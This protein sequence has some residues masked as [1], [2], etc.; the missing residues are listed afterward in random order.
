MVMG[1]VSWKGGS[2]EVAKPMAIARLK[3]EDV[4]IFYNVIETF[5]QRKVTKVKRW[6]PSIP[7]KLQMA[8]A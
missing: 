4:C 7:F 3:M 1:G 5:W 6:G 8:L 2:G